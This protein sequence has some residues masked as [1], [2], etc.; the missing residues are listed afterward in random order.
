MRRTP[1]LPGESPALRTSPRA[2]DLVP[3]I[4][5]ATATGR[6]CLPRETGRHR[7]RNQKLIVVARTTPAPVPIATCAIRISSD[8]GNMPKSAVWSA[9][10]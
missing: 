4:S 7:A 10:S 6:R 5:R 1:F 8:A 3:P 2:Q 9:T